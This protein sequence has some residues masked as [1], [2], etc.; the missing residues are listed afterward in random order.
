MVT[1]KKPSE[2]TDYNDFFDRYYFA[3]DCTDTMSEFNEK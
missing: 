3:S 2:D 1:P